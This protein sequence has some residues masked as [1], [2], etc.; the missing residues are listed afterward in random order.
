MGWAAATGLPS[1]TWPCSPPVAV[2]CASSCTVHTAHR[3]AAL[4]TPGSPLLVSC[5]PATAVTL[6]LLGCMPG[7]GFPEGP[8]LE[9]PEVAWA[10]AGLAVPTGTRVP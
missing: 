2:H 5:F 4:T 8:G 3:T 1:A 9:T 10:G 6:S 7:S